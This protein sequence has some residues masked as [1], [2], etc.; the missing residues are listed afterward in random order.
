MFEFTAAWSTVRD[1]LPGNTRRVFGT[2]P[3]DRVLLLR[4]KGLILAETLKL[5]L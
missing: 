2:Q 4:R 1:K 3:P 5:L